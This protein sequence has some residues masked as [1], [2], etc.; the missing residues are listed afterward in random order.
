MLNNMRAKIFAVLMICLLAFGNLQPAMASGFTLDVQETFTTIAGEETPLEGITVGGD[1]T[2]P[3]QLRVASG[4]LRIT[5]TTGLT[6][7]S[8]T[9]GSLLEFSGTAVNVNAA[10][11]TLTY[12]GT[13]N[14]T[15]DLEVSLVGTGGVYFEETGSVYRF[16][17]VPGGITWND[18]LVAAAQQTFNT[19]EEEIGGYLV[20]ITS[21]EENNF[22]SDRLQNA[23]GWMG[24]NDIAQEGVWR[25]IDTPE[26]V[27]DPGRGLQFWSGAGGGSAVDEMYENWNQ[28]EPN[29]SGNNEDCGQFLAGGTGQWNDLPCSGMTLSGYVV[30]FNNGEDGLTSGATAEIT[31]YSRPDV[32][33][34]EADTIIDELAFNVDVNS[35]GQAGSFRLIFEEG[36]EVVN[37]LTLGNLAPG[38]HGFTIDHEDVIDGVTVV[39]ATAPTLAEA[40]YDVTFRYVDVGGEVILSRLVE[41]VAFDL[42]VPEIVVLTPEN[43]GRT[44]RPNEFEMVFSEGVQLSGAGLFRIFRQDGNQLIFEGG[45][46]EIEVIGEGTGALS[47]SIEAEFVAGKSYYV[48]FSN[49]FFRDMRGRPVAAYDD[50]TDWTF[51]FSSSRRTLVPVVVPVEN[52][53]S[54]DT[55]LIDTQDDQ[56]ADLEDPKVESIIIPE[57]DDYYG[58]LWAPRS[59]LTGPSPWSGLI[60]PINLVAP[61]WY[62]RARNYDTVYLVTEDMKRRPFMDAQT[63]LTYADWEDVVW[64]EDATLQTLP[65][66]PMIVPKPEVVLVKVNSMR[67]VFFVQEGDVLPVLRKLESEAVARDLFGEDWAEYV[68]DI[69]PTMFRSYVVGEV[70]DEV[71]DL[72]DFDLGKLVKRAALR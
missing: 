9:S 20:I 36:G 5:E 51:L 53:N 70:I 71:G 66:M 45:F 50:A 12:Q 15:L 67:D 29:N 7:S 72:V 39:A 2:I 68:L 61:G 37:T 17:Q 60:E 57:F 55:G 54:L 42:F 35:A 48:Q 21:E 46:E 19:G 34:P 22:V 44:R 59:E 4:T 30:E 8:G 52:E 11:A 58:T 64:V 25:W 47:F 16:V 49:G 14:G 18:A 1:G 10:L 24:A 43:A 40:I 41:G 27:N 32:N 3:I 38:N 62:I 63:F 56:L 13:G 23:A 65:M 33:A 26:A 31:V 69:S 6:M 28:G